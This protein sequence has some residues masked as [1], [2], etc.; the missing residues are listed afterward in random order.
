MK[1]K[2]SSPFMKRKAQEERIMI[3]LKSVQRKKHMQ[4]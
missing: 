2:K 3:V 1:E 4:Q